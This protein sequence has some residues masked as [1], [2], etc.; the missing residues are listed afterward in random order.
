MQNNCRRLL[1]EDI[2]RI[3]K[4]NNLP[5]STE[6]VQ[7]WKYYFHALRLF[8][9]DLNGFRSIFYYRFPR[10]LWMKLFF[11]P[12]YEVIMWIGEL[13]GG[14][15]VFHHPFATVIN[16]DHIGYGCIFRNSTTIGNKKKDG[17]IVRPYLK[18]NVDVGTNAVILGGVTIGNNVI[19]G[20]GCVVT[21]D[22]PDNCVVAGNPAFIIRQDD[23]KCYKKL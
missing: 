23:Q 17:V 4:H 10:L 7:G 2:L 19:I 21:K 12:R 22:I 8:K 3:Y 14:G 9:N 20:A 5:L 18:N 16:A 1:Q 15:V 13:E 6:E 11:K